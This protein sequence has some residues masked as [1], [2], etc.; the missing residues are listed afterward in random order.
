MSESTP[1]INAQYLEQFSHRT[2]RIVGKVRQLRGE[3]ATIDASGTINVHLNRESHLQLNHAVE[4]IGKVQQDLSVRVLSSTDLGPEG[5]VD[6]A[7]IDAVVDATHRYHEIFY[8]KQ[9]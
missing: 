7:A 9:D 6:F 4:I 8:E 1:R 3:Q 2:V 5:S